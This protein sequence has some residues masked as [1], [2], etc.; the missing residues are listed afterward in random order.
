MV[1]LVKTTKTKGGKNMNYN[2]FKEVKRRKNTKRRVEN[3][4][5]LSIR[6]RVNEEEYK[7]IVDTAN[8][9][10]KS[11]SAYVRDTVTETIKKEA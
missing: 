6:I 10:K 2:Q 8:K 9:Q 7:L 11:L 1:F 5:F 3:P 4:R